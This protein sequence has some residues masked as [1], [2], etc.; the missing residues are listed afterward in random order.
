M[1][2]TYKQRDIEQGNRNKRMAEE[3][4]NNFGELDGSAQFTPGQ[5]LS[6]RTTRMAGEMGARALQLLN[7]PAEKQRTDGWMAAFGMSNEGMA[8]NEARAVQTAPPEPA[9]E[10]ASEPDPNKD[11]DPRP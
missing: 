5:D 9:P 7:D 10:Q 2:F 8:F 3:T 6:Q 4:P 11:E 1:D